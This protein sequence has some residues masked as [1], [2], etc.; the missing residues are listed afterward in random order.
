MG[1]IA[2]AKKP[3]IDTYLLMVFIVA[4]MLPSLQQRPPITVTAEFWYC[5]SGLAVPEG[6][7]IYLLHGYASRWANHRALL[8]Y[9]NTVQL[10]MSFHIISINATTL[11][12]FNKPDQLVTHRRVVSY[13]LDVCFNKRFL[14]HVFNGHATPLHTA[15]LFSEHSLAA[16]FRQAPSSASTC[17]TWL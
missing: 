13:R 8:L 1:A 10:P 7:L 4:K 5:H 14:I 17:L 6:G 12:R 2:P 3:I 15:E 16:V 9:H 11:C